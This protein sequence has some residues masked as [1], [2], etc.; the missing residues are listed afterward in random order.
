MTPA[1][2]ANDAVLNW[3]AADLLRRGRE[4]VVRRRA[5]VAPDLRPTRSAEPAGVDRDHPAAQPAASQVR[6]EDASLPEP[7]RRSAFGP[8]HTDADGRHRNQVAA[9]RRPPRRVVPVTDARRHRPRRWRRL[10]SIAVAAVVA[11]ASITSIL[12]LMG[13]SDDRALEASGPVTQL[14]TRPLM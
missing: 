2:L 1:H 6:V 5:I 9:L 3:V 8:P 4:Q 12:V 13:T 7:A 14:E 10:G 11:S